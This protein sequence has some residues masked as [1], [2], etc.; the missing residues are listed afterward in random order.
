[1]K[2]CLKEIID[3]IVEEI[4]PDK[5]ILFGSR[6]TDEDIDNSDYDIFILKKG[7]S[8]RRKLEQKV[9]HRFIGINAGIDIIIDTP[10]RFEKL[11]HNP[12][13]IYQEILR[14]GKV[15]YERR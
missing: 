3:R 13:M 5:I 15:I 14:T 2:E 11:K 4:S 10:E 7:I 12:F 8:N 6:A 1:M 9:Y